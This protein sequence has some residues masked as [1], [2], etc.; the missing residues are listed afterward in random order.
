MTSV[1][2]VFNEGKT[3]GGNHLDEEAKSDSLKPISNI[4]LG[5]LLVLA[6]VHAKKNYNATNGSGSFSEE[7][8]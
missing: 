7:R 4:D 8:K 5:E 1:G 6:L 2:W 3:S